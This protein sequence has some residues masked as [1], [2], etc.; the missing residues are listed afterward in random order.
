MGSVEPR[1][2]THDRATDDGS[3]RAGEE[4][5]RLVALSCVVGAWAVLLWPLEYSLLHYW[6]PDFVVTEA[7]TRF[8]LWAIVVAAP[9]CGGLGGL[10]TLF[11]GVRHRSWV[12]IFCGIVALV[13]AVVVAYYAGVAVGIPPGS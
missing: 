1:S 5:R 2:T 4:P 12:A 6:L 9:A 10:F 3:L 8:A 7:D 13:S 11:E